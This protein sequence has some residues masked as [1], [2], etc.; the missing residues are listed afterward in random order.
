M[1]KI[2]VNIRTGKTEDDTNYLMR[3]EQIGFLKAVVTGPLNT[4]ILN[5]DIIIAITLLN[6]KC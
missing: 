5:L 6:T 1:T 4:A 2:I 3:A